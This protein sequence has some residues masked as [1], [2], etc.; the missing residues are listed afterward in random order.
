MV[1]LQVALD[2]L[3]TEEALIIADSCSEGGA[4]IFEAGTPLIKC[5]GIKAVADLKKRFP[6]KIIVADMKTMDTGY[7]ETKLAAKAGADKVCI[8]ALAHDK[9]IKAAIKAGQDL[10]IDVCADLINVKDPIKRAK[11]LE[12]FGI[13]QVVFHVAIDEQ[14]NSEYPYPTL[15]KLCEE[16]DISVA[17]A[18]GL[19]DKKIPE[20]V[21]AGADVIV[22]GRFITQSDDPTRITEIIMKVLRG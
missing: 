6:K 22:I 20:V 17:A 18:G 5:E 14:L 3:T 4:K 13:D 21:K 7:L 16:V 15:R 10:K 11:E 9:T 1:E 2:V 12:D 19:N 8:L